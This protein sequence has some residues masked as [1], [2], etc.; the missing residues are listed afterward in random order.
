MRHFVSS[1]RTAPVSFDDPKLVPRI[2][3]SPIILDIGSICST[4][5]GL[6]EKYNAFDSCPATSTLIDFKDP[7]AAGGA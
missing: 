5:G 3:S 2:S 4:T 1:M 6:K 7:T